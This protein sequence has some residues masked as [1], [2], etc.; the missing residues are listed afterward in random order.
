MK[1]YFF[2]PLLVI[3]TSYNAPPIAA[4]PLETF[5]QDRLWVLLSA[6]DATDS[7]CS[8]YYRDKPRLGGGY[9][10]GDPAEYC[11]RF[12]NA[13]AIYLAHNGV[14]GVKPAHLR[15]PAFWDSLL[16]K[17]IAIQACRKQLGLW[18]PDHKYPRRPRM[19]DY[20][21]YE[22]RRAAEREYQKQETELLENHRQA[23]R[24]CNPY[25]KA[26]LARDI[27]I[28]DCHKQLGGTDYSLPA[29]KIP[30]EPMKR[31]YTTY[32]EY[33]AAMTEYRKQGRERWKEHE[34]AWKACYPYFGTHPTKQDDLEWLG[35]SLTPSLRALD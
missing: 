30:R 23:R 33:S 2:V 27:A 21:T 10:V 28:Q 9:L 26:L 4:S 34:R 3:L 1:Q 29:H 12:T 15:T 11:T 32:K 35:I 31:D 24:A 19:T 22:E 16:A 7:Y 5:D 13:L 18:P 25:V 20:D 14:S 6:V 8:N 17:E